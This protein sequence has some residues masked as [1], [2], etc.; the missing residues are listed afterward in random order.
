MT[1]LTDISTMEKQRV[2]AEIASQIEEFLRRGGRIDVLEKNSQ[3]RPASVGS[4]WH[5]NDDPTDFSD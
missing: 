1:K 5:N 2:R 3:H 4:I